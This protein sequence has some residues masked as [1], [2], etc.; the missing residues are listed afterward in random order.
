VRRGGEELLPAAARHV[1]VSVTVEEKGP[2]LGD[3]DRG[4]VAAAAVTVSGDMHERPLRLPGRNGGGG[5][6]YDGRGGGG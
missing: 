2:E 5:R 1:P 6:A 3:E 4:G